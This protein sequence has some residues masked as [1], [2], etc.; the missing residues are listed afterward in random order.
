M[1]IGCYTQHRLSDSVV[2][3]FSFVL[4]ERRQKAFKL[5][6]WSSI[7]CG[8]MNSPPN[9]N[10][11]NVSILERQKFLVDGFRTLGEIKELLACYS[12]DSSLQR[13]RDIYISEQHTRK[14]QTESMKNAQK[15]EP[16]CDWF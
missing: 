8:G 4:P 14:F 1:E 12:H 15:E 16:K 10:S 7:T 3:T 11:R 2:V 5:Y 6:L 9:T 13:S